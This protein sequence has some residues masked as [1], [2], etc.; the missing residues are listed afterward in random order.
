MITEFNPSLEGG[1][2]VA[3]LDIFKGIDDLI[4]G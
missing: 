4:I 1:S 2:R 3:C